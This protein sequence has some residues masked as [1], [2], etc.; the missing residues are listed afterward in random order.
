MLSPMDPLFVLL[1]VAWG[2]RARFM[3][4]ED[5]AAQLNNSW[6]LRVEALTPEKVELV[7]DI[8][9]T[10]EEGGDIG[11]LYVKA[12]ESKTLVWLRT[13]VERVAKTLASQEAEAS[14]NSKNNG[15]FDQHVNLP[16]SSNAASKAEM[17]PSE[18][19][20]TALHRRSAIDVIGD[21]LPADWVP[22]LYKSFDISKEDAVAKMTAKAAPTSE[23]MNDFSRFDRRQS[24]EKPSK[25]P[26]PSCDSATKKKSK[27]ANVDRSGMKSLTSFFTKK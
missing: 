2:Q 17:A 7:C 13:K 11:G 10:G 20:V 4:V 9:P 16:E 8:Q 5:L 3:S 25:R 18:L 24:V 14:A 1:A 23:A 27:L 6:L 19:K 21:Y 26:T 22:L 12:S 15:A